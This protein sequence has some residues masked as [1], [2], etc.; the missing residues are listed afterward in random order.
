MAWPGQAGRPSRDTRVVFTRS[1]RLSLRN[2]TW[3]IIGL[4][5]P[6]LYLV[7]Y[8]VRRPHLPPRV[9]LMP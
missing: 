6:I 4:T 9:R 7:L 3:V 1:L 8:V 2:P 5:Q